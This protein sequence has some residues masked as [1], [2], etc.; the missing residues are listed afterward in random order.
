MNNSIIQ[1]KALFVFFLSLF[2]LNGCTGKDIDVVSKN[3]ESRGGFEKL[4]S[5]HSKKI[6]GKFLI[7]EQPEVPFIIFTKRPDFIRIESGELLSACDGKSNWWVNPLAGINE[8]SEMPEIEASRLR[9]M[10]R[11]LWGYLQIAKDEAYDIQ[12]IG[13]EILEGDELFILKINKHGDEHNLY[14]DA[15]TFLEK[16][17]VGKLKGK[18][19]KAEAVFREYKKIDGILMAHEFDL[20][21][22]GKKDITTIFDNIELNPD[23]DNS[24][25]RKP[26]TLNLGN[27]Q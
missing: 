14:L 6:T 25:F 26:A 7:R 13:K 5:V 4:Q 16:K 27:N 15:T 1:F 3:I 12:F 22:N 8:S 17:L 18:G 11:F 10:Y 2:I 20:I 19:V 21:V 9:D 23:I 24:I